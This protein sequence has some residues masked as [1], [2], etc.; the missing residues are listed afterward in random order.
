[1]RPLAKLRA[2]RAHAHARC[3]QWVRAAVVLLLTPVMASAAD[4]APYPAES[5]VY[6]VDFRRFPEV[7]QCREING[8]GTLGFSHRGSTA[9]YT[10]RGFPEARQLTCTLSNG[11]SFLLDAWYM[12]DLDTGWKGPV[13]LMKRG[14]IRGV[15]AKLTY[16]RAARM[17]EA[18]Y[19]FDTYKGKYVENGLPSYIFWALHPEY[20][21]VDTGRRWK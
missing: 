5:W 15:R 2:L 21:P 7:P 16:K 20:K 10:L 9:T 1:M 14:E 18:R 12:F 3:A 17:V 6:R 13:E 19:H 11:K 8:R 4:Y